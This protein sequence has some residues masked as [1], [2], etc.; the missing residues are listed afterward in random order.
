MLRESFPNEYRAPN[1]AD[2]TGVL[3]VGSFEQVDSR[4]A[5]YCPIERVFVQ[6]LLGG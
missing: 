2:L 5:G 1:P 6:N 4:V 3:A